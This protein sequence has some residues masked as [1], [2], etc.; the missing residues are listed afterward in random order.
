MRKNALKEQFAKGQK[1][2][3]GWVAV[4][5]SFQTEQYAQQGFDSVTVDMQHGAADL[6]DLIPLLQAINLAGPTAMVRVPW[7]EPGTIM[8]VLDSGAYGI[9]CP[10][11]NTKA[12]AEALV[13]A[14]RYPPIGKRSNGPYRASAYAGADY[15]MHANSEVLIFAMI[16]TT[17]AVANLDAI[18]SVKGLDGTYVGPTDLSLSM[19][20]PATLDPSDKDVLAAMKTIVDKT[21]KAGKIAGA[22]TDG[23]K[24][25]IKRFGEGFHFCTLLNDVRLLAN[26]AQAWVREAKGQAKGEGSKS[27]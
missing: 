21:V 10:M 8:R 26:A 6:S 4:P 20:K 11:I 17:E 9:I 24:T 5:N 1:V 12:E 14:G 27:Y 18:L 13:A 7:N 3:N 15:Q 25:A 2:V 19:G 16:E 22:H 23:P